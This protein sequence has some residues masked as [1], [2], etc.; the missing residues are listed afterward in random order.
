M[1]PG[2]APP[3]GTPVLAGSEPDRRHFDLATG[4]G[5]AP[6]PDRLEIV[7]V[8]GR[9]RAHSSGADL[10]S[11]RIGGAVLDAT[12]MCTALPSGTYWL[13]ASSSERTAARRL[14]LVR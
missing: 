4:S 11:L 1:E 5:L 2:D 12:R 13:R 9:V 6:V 10:L 3:D 14:Q 7:D 8:Q